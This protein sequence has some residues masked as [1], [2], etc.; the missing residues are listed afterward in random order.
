[1]IH[2]AFSI[3]YQR[4]LNVL[5]VISDVGFGCLTNVIWLAGQL[6]FLE[7]VLIRIFLK[8]VPEETS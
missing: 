1:M 6:R 4:L 7:R 5:V 3:F 2:F 8:R